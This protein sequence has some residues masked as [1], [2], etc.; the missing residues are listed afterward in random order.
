MD[1]I[2]LIN[3]ERDWTSRDVCNKLQNVFHTK[4]IGHLGTLDPFAEGLLAVTINKANKIMQFTD[5]FKKTYV[6]DLLLGMETSTGD[7]TGEVINEKEVGDISI[8]QIKETLNKFL[9]K[10]KQVP[11]MTS[12]IHYQGRKLY[13][14]AHEGETVQREA[15]EV[16]IYDISLISYE[17]HHLIFRCTVS[18]GTYIRVL[19]EDIAKSLNTLGHLTYL[20]REKVGP[21]DVKDAIK[22]SEVKEDSPLINPTDVLTHYRQITVSGDTL[23]K[24]KDGMSMPFDEISD[25]FILLKDE[26]NHAIAIYQRVGSRHMYHCFR[27]LW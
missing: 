15:R 25:E 2:L 16:E 18:K 1:G 24:V 11:P 22:I 26:E 3:K 21:L 17:N 20:F 19:G 23:K 10:I 7:L 14:I 6:A 8:K 4:S 9:G 5:D 27:G 12:A 13:E